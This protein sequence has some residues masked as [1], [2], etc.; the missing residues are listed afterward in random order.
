MCIG[1]LHLH[2]V[3][4]LLWSEFHFCCARSVEVRFIV[5]GRVDYGVQQ[6]TG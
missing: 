6:V 2:V 1:A 4:E 5:A 3:S